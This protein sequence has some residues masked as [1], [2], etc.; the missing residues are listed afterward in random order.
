MIPEDLAATVAA[1]GAAVAVAD[2]KTVLADFM[3]DRIGQLIAAPDVPN[4]LKSAAVQ[5]ITD[6][7]DGLYDAI[8]RYTR[9]DDS[10]FELRSRWVLFT[11]G[12]WRVLS[13][14]NIPE[15][16]PW[17]D[18]TG[19]SDDGL[20]IPH[21]EGLKAGELVMQRCAACRTWVWSP[22]PICPSCHSFEMSWESVDPI[23]TVYA[24]TR[25]WQAFT[26][27]SSGHL[28]YVVV[29][30][31]LP[32]ADGRRVLGIL[33][34][35]DGVTPR[36]GAPVRGRIEQPPDDKHWPLMRWHLTESTGP[37]T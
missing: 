24:W 26:G 12:T 28:P 7:G 22:R 20:D 27:E 1:H 30:V 13:V 19:P 36:I 18:L 5:S 11:D 10:Q 9:P 34:R 2:N 23:G 33:E 21:W 29:L 3:P 35:A 15:T 4:K 8:I 32:G 25:T 37:A 17:M 6:V 16:A 14:R 31:E